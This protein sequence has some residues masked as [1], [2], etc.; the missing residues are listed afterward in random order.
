MKLFYVR[1][2]GNVNTKNQDFHNEEYCSADDYSCTCSLPKNVD[3]RVI[4]CYEINEAIKESIDCRSWIVIQ[5][6]SNSVVNRCAA[7][8]MLANQWPPEYCVHEWTWRT[9]MDRKAL[10]EIRIRAVKRVEADESPEVVIK[11]LGRTRPRIYEWLALY[12][13]GGIDVLI[14]RKVP[15]KKVNSQVNSSRKC[16]VLL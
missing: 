5:A 4:H 7:L 13:E 1:F 2:A 3:L 12:R 15:G 9:S 16:I 11:A 8:S 10:E 14:S 6:R